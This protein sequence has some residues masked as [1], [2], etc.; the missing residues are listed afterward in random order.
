ML[1]RATA[2]FVF[3]VVLL[4]VW[5]YLGL[6]RKNGPVPLWLGAFLVITAVLFRVSSGALGM[7]GAIFLL[8]PEHSATYRMWVGGLGFVAGMW[9][10]AIAMQFACNLLR[11]WLGYPARKIQWINGLKR[12]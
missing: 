10:A 2:L 12:K 5:E 7:M 6:T 8:W 9:I 4:L 3:S 1:E 11:R